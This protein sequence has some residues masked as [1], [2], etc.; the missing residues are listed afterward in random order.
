[1]H[2]RL[3]QYAVLIKMNISAQTDEKKAIHAY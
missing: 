2:Q 3:Y 1:M